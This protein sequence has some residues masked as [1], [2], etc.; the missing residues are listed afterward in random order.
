MILY[1]FDDSTSLAIVEILKQPKNNFKT[2]KVVDGYYNRNYDR[3]GQIYRYV[4]EWKIADIGDIVSLKELR[5][6][7]PEY[8]L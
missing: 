5:E 4:P 7:Y 8:L 2:V 1:K 3:V 6:K